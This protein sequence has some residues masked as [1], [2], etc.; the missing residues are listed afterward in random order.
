MVAYADLA[1]LRNSPLVQHLTSMAQPTSVDKDYSDFMASTGF[2]YRRDLDRVVFASRPAPSAQTLVFAEGRFDRARIEQYA[3]RS[4][5]L[6][7]ENGHAVYVV[8]SGNAGKNA[9]LAFL[10]DNRIVLS[11]GG[12]LSA[13]FAPH[14]DSQLDPMLRERVSR[15]AGSPLF[16]VAK[17]PASLTAGVPGS[18]PA[19]A[20]AAPMSAPF[21][22][23]QWVSF[24]AR[25]DGATML[26]SVEGECG[27]PEAAKKLASSLEFV[28]GMVHGGLADPKSRGQMKPET[29]AAADRL[30]QAVLV[31]TE[32]ERVRMLLTVTQDM[33]SAPAPPAGAVLSPPTGH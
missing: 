27:D 21:A 19:P 23:L 2:D 9:S 5:K 24:A 29:A 4:G 18:G 10:A 14:S 6:Q 20:P 8:P 7:T 22:S 11:D 25:P 26:L 31:T 1:T 33:L 12:D 15:V 32:A 30:L 3:L 28:R 13:V 17:A 16:A